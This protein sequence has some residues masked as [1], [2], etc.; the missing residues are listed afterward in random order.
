MRAMQVTAYD[1]PLTLQ[2]L[3]MPVHLFWG[4]DDEILGEP[5]FEFYRTNLPGQ[6][7]AQRLSGF[8]HAPHIDGLGGLMKQ[9]VPWLKEA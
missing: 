8:G 2:E 4:A 9:I 1:E 5:H 7:H 3:E 6:A